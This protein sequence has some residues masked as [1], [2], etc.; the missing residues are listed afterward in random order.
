MPEIKNEFRYQIGNVF[1][2]RGFIDVV[3]G[4]QKR[5]RI[6]Q[7]VYNAPHLKIMIIE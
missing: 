2:S 1:W 4:Y 6:S 3:R 7:R 5:D